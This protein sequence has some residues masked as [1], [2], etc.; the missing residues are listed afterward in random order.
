MSGLL[1]LAWGKIDPIPPMGA[2]MTHTCG[3]WNLLGRG[4][5]TL[6]RYFLVV[7]ET[8]YQPPPNPVVSHREP[9]NG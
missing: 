9:R 4:G 2:V 6:E 3:S 7:T 1:T 8:R 5:R